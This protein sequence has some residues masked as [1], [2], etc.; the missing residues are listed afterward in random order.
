MTC[1]VFYNVSGKGNEAAYADMALD[2]YEA[3][4]RCIEILA[5]AKCTVMFRMTQCD[6]SGIEINTTINITQQ[7]NSNVPYS[8]IRETLKKYADES[9]TCDISVRDD[10]D[11]TDVVYITILRQTAGTE[12]PYV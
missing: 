6:L 2:V 8:E 5:F 9:K 1:E 10:E 3:V 4:E 11:E 7:T 12:V